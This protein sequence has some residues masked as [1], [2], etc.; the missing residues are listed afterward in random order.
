[1]HSVILWACQAHRP[2]KVGGRL[3]PP[4][5]AKLKLARLTKTA[6]HGLV[7][8]MID[9]RNRDQSHPANAQ[10]GQ[11]RHPAPTPVIQ[12]VDRAS[13][14]PDSTR[15]PARRTKQGSSWQIN[16]GKSWCAGT[17]S[18]RTEEHLELR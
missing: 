13:A 3:C 8:R 11:G 7:V 16:P 2:S 18:T 12:E 1:M 9:M 5:V 4:P 14:W 17:D 15:A 6:S 10:R